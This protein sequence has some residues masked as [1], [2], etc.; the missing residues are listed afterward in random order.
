MA[1]EQGK[2]LFPAGSLQEFADS[3]ESPRKIMMMVKAGKPVDDFIEQIIPYLDKG[4]VLIDGGNTHFPIPTGVL[5][6]LKIKDF[7]ILAQVFQ[8]VRRVR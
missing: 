3:I 5:L 1:G 7:F 2:T 8:A 6:T 4:D